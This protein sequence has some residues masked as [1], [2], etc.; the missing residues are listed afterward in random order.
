MRYVSAENF[1]HNQED[2]P[3]PLRIIIAPTDKL[4]ILEHD[5]QLVA[6]C[7]SLVSHWS[8]FRRPS[9][10]RASPFPH[11]FGD[12]FCLL[13]KCVDIDKGRLFFSLAF[14]RRKNPRNRHPQFANR[15]SILRH[16]SLGISR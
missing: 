4:K 15:Q 12:D 11:V 10:I 3:E 14:A 2:P 16:P 1:P 8:S 5:L 6:F 9:T 7:P 13:T